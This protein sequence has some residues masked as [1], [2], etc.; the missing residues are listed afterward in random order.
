MQRPRDSR[1]RIPTLL[2]PTLLYSILLCPILPWRHKYFIVLDTGEDAL[3]HSDARA[4]R[5]GSE[6]TDSGTFFSPKLLRDRQDFSY[7]FLHICVV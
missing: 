1:W 7:C 2:W 5:E 6:D 3:M 4:S